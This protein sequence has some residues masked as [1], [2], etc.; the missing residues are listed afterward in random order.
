MS[1]AAVELFLE[2]GLAAVTI[3]QIVAAAGIAKGS[4][5]RYFEDKEQVVEVLLE[6]LTQALLAAFDACEQALD[7][8]DSDAAI[9][10]AYLDL[11]RL[12]G[13]ALADSP[14]VALLYLQE[15]R[16]PR[17]GVRAPITELSDRIAERA[18]QLSAFARDRGLLRDLDPRVQGLL[19]LGACERLLYDHLSGR[20]R[21]APERVATQIVSIILDGVRRR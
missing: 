13:I 5:Y 11:A 18:E 8:A 7:R 21:D 19:V 4:F 17:A 15:S 16:G 3:D 20:G 12:V 10:A 6:P 1:R 9:R 14:R 2:Q